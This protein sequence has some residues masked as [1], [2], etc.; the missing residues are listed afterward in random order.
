M[1]YKVTRNQSTVTIQK[2]HST[3]KKQITHWESHHFHKE[4]LKLKSVKVFTCTLIFLFSI[5]RST[6]KNEPLNLEFEY[7]RQHT[8]LLLF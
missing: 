1:K 6:D 4:K 7:F 2:S 5:S 3:E 8:L